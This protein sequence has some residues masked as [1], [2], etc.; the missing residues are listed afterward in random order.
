MGKKENQPD[1][2]KGNTHEQSVMMCAH[3]D[4]SL[5]ANLKLIRDQKK[6]PKDEV[7]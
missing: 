4:S 2:K 5:N 7:S 6:S 1:N 3:E